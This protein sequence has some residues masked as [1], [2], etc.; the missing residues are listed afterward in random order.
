M[1]E[2][3]DPGGMMRVGRIA[4]LAAVIVMLAASLSA[5]GASADQGQSASGVVDDMG[6][7]LHLDGVTVAA[8]PDVAP[9]GTEMR[10]TSD[11]KQ[12]DGLGPHAES[13][14]GGI[15]VTL[16]DGLQ[17][18]SPISI[19]FK[20]DDLPADVEVDGTLVSNVYALA[21]QTAAGEWAAPTI[22][23]A[24][25]T[26]GTVSAQV[27]HLSWFSPISIAIGEAW[28]AVKQSLGIESPRPD[29]ATDVP[30][31]NGV[32]LAAQPWNAWVCFIPDG[33]GVE[34]E[35]TSN[36]NVPFIF[37]STP[38]ASVVSSPGLNFS[39]LASQ[40]FFDS[41][42]P[43]E[44][45]L[46]QH[47]GSVRL[48]FAGATPD[49][50]SMN[51]DGTILILRILL[52]VFGALV[53]DKVAQ[54]LF[55]DLIGELEC[56]ADL[57]ETVTPGATT[58]DSVGS[59]TAAFFSCSSL[60]LDTHPGASLILWAVGAAPGSVIALLQGAINEAT[61][62]DKSEVVFLSS[63]PARNPLNCEQLNAVAYQ[64]G[65]QASFDHGANPPQPIG[66]D[67]FEVVAGPLAVEIMRRAV[68][69]QGCT[70]S[71]SLETG[72]NQWNARLA[73]ADRQAL[74]DGLRAS[75]DY[76]ESQQGGADVFTAT[77]EHS[78]P[79]SLFGEWTQYLTYA[80]AGNTW[81]T[82]EAMEET[83]PLLD[84]ALAE[85]R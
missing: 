83:L 24:D 23:E 67:L 69:V 20:V 40:V 70:Y 72:I 71:T 63:A 11:P 14:S 45:N 10:L 18:A 43:G 39:A 6:I 4:G 54:A 36:A 44:G 56:A 8:G 13:L 73:A 52:D 22:A 15:S 53:P 35:M 30:E 49:S 79:D 58:A 46:L 1:G 51:Q 81:I 47:G 74:V 17:P 29:C 12:L 57:L 25:T 55:L 19:T 42:Y 32:K 77:I 85:A 28:N 64:R 41:W 84:S 38:G 34:V 66:A 60:A 7:E 16:G 50:I 37:R 48:N 78:D 26:S 82:I 5:C 21:S 33:D 80:F 61:G 62:V 59:L 76:A 68:S 65:L 3:L 2:V 27:T 9:A 31:L 75:P